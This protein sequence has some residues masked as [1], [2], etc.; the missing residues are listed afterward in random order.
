MNRTRKYI[1][2]DGTEEYLIFWDDNNI[3]AI[4]KKGNQIDTLTFPDV[5]FDKVVEFRKDMKNA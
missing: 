4:K 1:H 5:W 2:A 3:T